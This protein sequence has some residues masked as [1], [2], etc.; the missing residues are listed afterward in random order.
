MYIWIHIAVYRHV[1]RKGAKRR[2]REGQISFGY[3]K[4]LQFSAGNSNTLQHTATHCNT[5]MLAP[6]LMSA[7]RN[8]QEWVKQN[9]DTATHCSALDTAT[10][11]SA[12]HYTTTHCDTLQH[13]KA[14]VYNH[15]RQQMEKKWAKPKPCNTLQ[16]TATHCKTLQHTATH[17]NTR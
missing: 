9:S 2:K 3:C 7:K 5:R 16:H 14:G 8:K 10:H 13:M 17:C 6:T 11:C 4:T 1:T 15:E 12:L